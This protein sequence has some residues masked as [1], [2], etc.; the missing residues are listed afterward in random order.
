MKPTR[1][2]T[3]GAAKGNPGPGGFGAIVREGGRV[4]E[5]GGRVSH[6]TNNEMELRAVV[7]SL[8]SL[9][10]IHAS[11]ELYTDSKYVAEGAARWIFGWIKN[12]WK[13]K[14]GSD[15]RNK[16]LWEQLAELLPGTQIKWCVI[17][18][19]SGIPDNERADA[20]A[21]GFGSGTHP[22]M[23]AGPAQS[24][25]YDL[26]NTSYDLVKKQARSDTRA[27]QAKTAYSY[28]SLKD[29]VVKTHTTW[30]E[31]EARVKGQ[32]NV[33]FKKALDV[34]EEKTIIDEFRKS[35]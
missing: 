17:P 18:G 4:Q 35:K 10:H 1:I 2:F 33:R 24:Y 7:E 15:V 9:E 32:K 34:H 25:S 8:R 19:H 6:T 23:Y 5:L 3:D 28:I 21:S 11:V 14:T 20:I 22:T 26:D 31:C 12:G 29:G 27:R 13:T 16:E 30:A